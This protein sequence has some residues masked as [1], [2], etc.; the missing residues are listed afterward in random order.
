MSLILSID[1]A[2]DIAHICIARDGVILA[3]ASNNDQ[4]EHGAFLQP[5]INQMLEKAGIEMS[6]LN[7]VAVVAGPG[8]YTGLRVGM[9]SAKGICY[10]LKKPLISL[11]TLAV[12]TEA[13]IM[14]SELTMPD[15][16]GLYCPMIDARRMEVFTAVYNNNREPVIPPVALVLNET[17]FANIMLKYNILYFGNG[18]IKWKN[19]VKNSN[20][21]F[22]EISG[23]VLAMSK[24]AAH[25]FRLQQFANLAYEQPYY[26]KE[27]Y[28]AN[29]GT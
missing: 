1:T 16:D 13:A 25:K 3:E 22:M 26:L 10:A 20:A 2:I 8:S 23:N 21:H 6:S 15:F 14:T 28:D 12:L 9:A 29:T 27:F 11:N 5:A 24:L 7:A 4:K 18:A 19:I 17:S